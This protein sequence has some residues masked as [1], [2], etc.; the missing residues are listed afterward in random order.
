MPGPEWAVGELLR[1]GGLTLGVVESATGGLV[2]HLITNVPGS[3]D[4]YKG[5]VTAYSNDIKVRI[6]GVSQASI[7][8]FGAVSA[9]VAEEMAAGGRRVLAVDICLADTGVAGPGGATAEKPTGLFYLGLAHKGGN[10]SQRHIFHG[11]REANKMGAA[12]AALD[13]LEKYLTGL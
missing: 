5:S 7:A 1:R 4:Y 13:W 12:L 8:S 10:F 6:V 9:P 11:E 2:S 3:S